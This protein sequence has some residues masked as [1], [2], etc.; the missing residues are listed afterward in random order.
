MFRVTR[1]FEF[2]YAHRLLNYVGKCRRLHGH[3]AWAVI[4]IEGPSLDERGI[5][6]DF[7]DIK[8]TI[9]EWIDDSLDHNLLLYREDP[10]I[11]ILI[12]QEE[13]FFI[14]DD[15]PSAENIARLIFDQA[16]VL[17]LPVIEVVIRET[18]NCSA[19]Y[20]NKGYQF[21]SRGV[22]LV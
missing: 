10:L 1:E 15:H 4:T 5:L 13:S 14:M 11:P 21:P 22:P 7:A 2:C 12:D 17:G 20:T 19:S 18:G 8:S 3:N 16:V 9:C 6:V